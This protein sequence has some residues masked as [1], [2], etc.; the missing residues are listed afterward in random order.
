MR[1]GT[2]CTTTRVRKNAENINGICTTVRRKKKRET[3]CNFRLCIRTRSLS[4]RTS[5]GHVTDVTSGALL[6]RLLCN[7]RLRTRRTYFGSGHV[8]DVTYGNVTNVTSG[9]GHFRSRDWSNFRSCAM[10][11]SSSILRK[12][13]FVRTNILLLQ[14]EGITKLG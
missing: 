13:A 6:R 10:V 1:N 12:S 4:V 14:I 5:S 3:L 11:R 7:F 2:F 9:Q 8:T